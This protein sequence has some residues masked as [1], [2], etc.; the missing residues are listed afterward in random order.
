MLMMLMIMK[1]NGDLM[2]LLQ[3]D[4]LVFKIMVMDLGKKVLNVI[5]AEQ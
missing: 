3:M 4:L 1:I 2:L 5:M